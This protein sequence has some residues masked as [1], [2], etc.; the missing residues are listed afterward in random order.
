MVMLADRLRD[1][2]P[3]LIPVGYQ[4]F[5]HCTSQR[6]TLRHRVV[7]EALFHFH[8]HAHRFKLQF[9]VV[10][11]VYALHGL[12]GPGIAAEPS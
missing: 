4:S 5:S 2:P 9:F 3:L 11:V 12:A 8:G 10:P 1:E 6:L 7:F